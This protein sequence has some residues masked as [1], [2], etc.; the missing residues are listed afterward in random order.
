VEEF[1]LSPE[2]QALQKIKE[3]AWGMVSTSILVAAIRL[4]L[5]DVV[6]D[7]PA[8]AAALADKVG[9]EPQTLARLLDALECRGVFIR[10]PDGRYRHNEVSRLL[11]DDDPNS[12]SYLVR[13][14][15][16]PLLW[17][18][19][20]RLDESI[21][22]GEAV[23]PQI[24]G[25]YVFDYIHEDDPAAGMVLGRGMSQ[26]SRHTSV[27]VARSLDLSGARVVADIG[28]G[29]GHLLKTILEHHP[30]VRGVLFDLP[31]VVAGA[32]AAL[33][34]GPLA[35]RVEILGGDCRAH[36]P[37]V[38]D[39]YVLKNVLEW[40]DDSSIA[41]LRNVATSARPGARV[42]VV[43]TLADHNPEPQV[44]T[45]LDLLLLLN[46]AGHKHTIDQVRGLFERSGLSFVGVRPTGTFLSF[47]EA[48]VPDAPR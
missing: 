38:A 16:H 20:P 30:D 17:P 4:G 33:R 11:R 43:Q 14:I 5:P 47:V 23:F 31:P 1:V 37:V 46:G 18:L 42:L 34:T 28:G 2:L 25:K 15:G 12:V 10:T 29:Q 3:C 39:V 44:T 7:E 21:R 24:Y 27:S 45:A 41:T 22:T 13:W 32:D 36:V 9:A 40:D 26:A 6:G 19:W 48:V 35:D 8:T